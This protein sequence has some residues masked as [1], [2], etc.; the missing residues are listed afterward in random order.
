MRHVAFGLTLL[1]SLSLAGCASP[2]DQAEQKLEEL[3]TALVEGTECP[4]LFTIFDQIDENATAFS[5]A[6][7]E[8]INVGCFSRASERTDGGLADAAPD[9]PWLGVP[10]ETVKPSAECED[11]AIV[12]AGEADST[13]AEPLINATLDSCQSVSE[14]MSVLALHPGVMGMVEGWIPDL[15]GL[16]SACFSYI[17]SAV[18]RDALAVGLEV[19]P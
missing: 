2:E 16:Q 3:R 12:A 1:L 6:Q 14:W 5:T 17:D 13:R 10:G 4:G 7:G 11:A 18:C 19:G 8:V 15:L 9:S